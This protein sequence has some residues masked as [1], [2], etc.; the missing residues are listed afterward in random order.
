MRKSSL[1]MLAAAVLLGLVAVFFARMFL[2]APGAARSNAAVQTV[3]AV[4]AAQAFAFGE[5]ITPDKLKVVQ[6]PANGIPAGSFQRVIDLIGS[7]RVAMRAIDANELVTDKAISGKNSRLSAST[8]LGPTMRAIA[9]PLG[10]TAGAGGFIAPGDRVDVYLTRPGEDDN[11]PYTD[12]LMQGVRVLAVGQDANVGLDKAAVVKTA[13]IEVT[14][15]QAQKA[16]LAQTVGQL[17]LSLR[18][19][20]DESRVRLETAQ[21]LDLNDGTITRLVR[22]PNASGSSGG[23]QER[24]GPAP[25]AAPRDAGAAPKAAPMGPSIEIFRGTKPTSYPVPSGS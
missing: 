5:K 6:W 2:L 7:D 18:N 13:T 23:E 17:S 16:A 15:L 10:E 12:L 4:V 22:K 9:L 25:S 19:I 11:Q 1:V 3:P 24:S 14:P 8:L 20:V 21:L